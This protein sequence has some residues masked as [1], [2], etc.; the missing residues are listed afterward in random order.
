MSTVLEVTEASC[1]ETGVGRR[2]VWRLTAATW[3]HL[4]DRPDVRRRC[5]A[6]RVL[7]DPS[8]SRSRSAASSSKDRQNMFDTPSRLGLRI[9]E[10]CQGLPDLQHCDLH[11]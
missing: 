1:A 5:L 8:G 3:R 7:I 6:M 10:R 2:D 9:N 11:H 4:A